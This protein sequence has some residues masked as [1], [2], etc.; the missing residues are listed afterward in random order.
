VKISGAL[1]CSAHLQN[2]AHDLDITM[3]YDLL[4]AVALNISLRI[5]NEIQ[6]MSREN[7]YG[8]KGP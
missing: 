6:R 4:A 3:F 8:K 1:P 2:D 7:R 5:L